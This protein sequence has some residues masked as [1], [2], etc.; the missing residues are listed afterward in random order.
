[1]LNIIADQTY[2]PFLAKPQTWFVYL[3]NL[4][5]SLDMLDTL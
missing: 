3:F 2:N 5:P 4:C 1:M